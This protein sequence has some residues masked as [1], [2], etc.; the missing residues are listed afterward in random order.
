[1]PGSGVRIGDTCNVA[2]L[3][4]VFHL[5]R[6]VLETMDVALAVRVALVVL[7]HEFDNVLWQVHLTASVHAIVQRRHVPMPAQST[8]VLCRP[9]D[10]RCIQARLCCAMEHT[11]GI[12]QKRLRTRAG[13]SKI[14]ARHE[15]TLS[16]WFTPGGPYGR[17]P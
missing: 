5:E 10:M 2:Q 3:L 8:C 7:C 15:L 17:H 12:W 16:A 13:T 9:Y 11:H 4:I 6:L 14:N 1:M